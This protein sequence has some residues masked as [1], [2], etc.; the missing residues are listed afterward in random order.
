M[1]SITSTGCYCLDLTSGKALWSFTVGVPVMST[2]LVTGNTVYVAAY[3]GRLYAL[4]SSPEAEETSSTGVENNAI[5]KT[6]GGIGSAHHRQ[7]RSPALNSV[8]SRGRS[9]Q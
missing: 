3:D 2:P 9:V 7:N 5:R 4:T 6:S 8:Q 1:P